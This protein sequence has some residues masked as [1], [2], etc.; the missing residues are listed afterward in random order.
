MTSFFYEM[1]VRRRCM[2]SLL[3]GLVIVASAQRKAD[4]QEQIDKL[5][6]QQQA[7]AAI[8]DMTM[9]VRVTKCVPEAKEVAIQWRRGGEGLGG[10]VTKGNFAPPNLPQPDIDGKLAAPASL[11]LGINQWCAWTAVEAVCGR[12]KSFEFPTITVGYPPQGPKQLDPPQEILVEFEFSERGKTFQAFSEPAPRGATVGF[13]FPAALLD[14]R[15]SQNVEFVA[16]LQGLSGHVRTRRERLETP[17]PEPASP[18]QKFGVLGHLAGYGQGPG[19]GL[20]KAVGFGVRHCNPEIVADECRTMQLL[21]INGLVD[22][23]SV[24]MVELAGQADRFRR[25]FWGGPG[26]GSPM[27]AVSS[28]TIGEPDGCPFDPR[29]KTTMAEQVERAIDQHE[30]SGAATKWG[31]WWDEIGVAAKGHV[32]DCPR[33]RDEF[34]EYLR[35]HAIVPADVGASTWDDVAP[36]P[37]WTVDATKASKKQTLAAP[38]DDAANRLRYY[39]TYR[40]MSFATGHLFPDSAQRLKQ[41]GISLYAMQGPTPSW[42]GSSLDWHEF[43][44]TGANTALVFET[45]NRDARSWQWESYLADIMRGISQRHGGLPMGCLV[46]P[47]RGAPQQRMLSV[48]SRGTEALEWYTYG[49]DY[50][51]GD[52]FSQSPDLLEDVADAGRFLAKAEPYLWQAKFGSEPNVGFCFPRAVPRSGVGWDPWA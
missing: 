42:N 36:F 17:F 22:E 6:R 38:P 8:A 9:R 32:N 2:S 48:V 4:A 27:A 44:D 3:I 11:L 31:L 7:A 24:K 29:L 10:T 1:V 34:R 45:S 28:K 52:S 33:C 14:G 19:G 21:G 18:P 25:V 40:F 47:H 13:V 51:K 37:L 41:A 50:A 35:R 43:Y 16:A 20:G 15:G 46:K 5:Q 30:R 39:Y 12:A 49:P 26:S 23:K